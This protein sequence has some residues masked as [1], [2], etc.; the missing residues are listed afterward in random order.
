ML[1]ICEGS[2]HICLCAHKITFSFCFCV[3][4]VVCYIFVCFMIQVM[5]ELQNE[6]R[7][8][9]IL[10]KILCIIHY[11]SPIDVWQKL[12]MRPSEPIIFLGTRCSII[13]S[14]Y[15]IYFFLSEF[16]Q[17]LFSKEFFITS[18]MSI[19]WQKVVCITTSLFFQYLKDLSFLILVIYSLSI[20]LL[21]NLILIFS[22][23]R[24]CHY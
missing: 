17:F 22:I 19:Y 5:P 8:F 12:F 10:C 15:I 11:I 4:V 2:L 16:S 14:V 1:I 9:S 6:L 3:L 18:N 7:V 21:G 23:N 13:S 20:F 24:L